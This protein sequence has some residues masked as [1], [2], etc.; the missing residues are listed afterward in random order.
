MS[1]S[2][3]QVNNALLRFDGLY[4]AFDQSGVAV[5]GVASPAIL[6]H[7]LPSFSCI[8]RS[9][10]RLVEH[11]DRHLWS[12]GKIG[13][14]EQS[15]PNFHTNSHISTAVL[16]IIILPFG[17]LCYNQSSNACTNCRP[18]FPYLPSMLLVNPA[19]IAVITLWV[20]A[21]ARLSGQMKIPKQRIVCPF[22]LWTVLFACVCGSG[23]SSG[24]IL[25]WK[26]MVRYCIAYGW[27]NRIN[28]PECWCS[29]HSKL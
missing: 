18:F 14:C 28:K 26:S 3:T 13:D 9:R 22:D 5:A 2:V 15:T 8:M 17:D 27:V 12:H 4:C 23:H 25:S 16:Q 6:R 20:R 21:K 19:S 11:N 29:W 24:L 1:L 7:T 10:W